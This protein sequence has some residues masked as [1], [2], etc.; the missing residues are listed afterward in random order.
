MVRHIFLW[1]LAEGADP[2]GFLERSRGASGRIGENPVLLEGSGT[3]G[4]SVIS[5]RPKP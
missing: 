1:K 3:T 4:S 5:S 2:K